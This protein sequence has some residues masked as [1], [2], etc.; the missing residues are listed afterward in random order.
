MPIPIRRGRSK[1]SRHRFQERGRLPHLRGGA[2]VNGTIEL[3]IQTR[4]ACL[5]ACLGCHAACLQSVG[6][7]LLRADLRG[8]D[9]GFALRIG[10]LLE[11]ADLCGLTAEMMRRNSPCTAPIRAACAKALEGAGELNQCAAACWQCA[12]LCAPMSDLLPLTR[13]EF[14]AQPEGSDS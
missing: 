12:E 14:S 10:L 2:N 9:A 4:R 8:D 6:N 5:E 11:T 3:P 7:A 13:A 1:W